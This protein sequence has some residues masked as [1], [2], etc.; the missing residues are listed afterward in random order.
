VTGASTCSP[1]SASLRG[2]RPMRAHED[3]VA[4]DDNCSDRE[5]VYFEARACFGQRLRHKL[6]VAVAHPPG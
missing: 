6:L 2:T 1:G 3:V 5:L 4:Q